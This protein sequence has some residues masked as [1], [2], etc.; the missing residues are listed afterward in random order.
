MVLLSCHRLLTTLL[1]VPLQ[2]PRCT[3]SVSKFGSIAD[4]VGDVKAM[5]IGLLRAGGLGGEPVPQSGDRD[6]PDALAEACGQWTGVEQD[7]AMEPVA[8]AIS[9]ER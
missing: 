4:G 8:K 3:E 9:Q 7:A 1:E 5:L 6:G 2:A